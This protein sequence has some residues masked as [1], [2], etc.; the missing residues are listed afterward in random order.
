MKNDNER[1]GD[2]V[3]AK[4]L[5]GINLHGDLTLPIDESEEK[6]GKW[7]VKTAYTNTF[8]CGCTAKRGGAASGLPG[9]NAATKVAEL[10]HFIW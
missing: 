5:A 7:E 9:P 1:V 2:E 6:A 4:H 8:L 3:L 10:K